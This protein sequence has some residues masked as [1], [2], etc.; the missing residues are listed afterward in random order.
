MSNRFSALRP[1]PVSG[2]P[3]VSRDSSASAAAELKPAP[4]LVTQA[5]ETSGG[6]SEKMID[7]KAKIHQ[8]LIED[9]NLIA[10]D[11]LSRSEVMDEVRDYVGEYAKQ[12]RLALNVA[13]TDDLVENIVDE[14]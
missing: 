12:E 4:E 13:E 10:L 3:A 9:L 7:V 1:V 11:R 14:M 2:F 8:K 5:A 6:T